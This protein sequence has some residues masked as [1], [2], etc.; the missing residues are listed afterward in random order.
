MAATPNDLAYFR[1]GEPLPAGSGASST[2]GFDYFRGGEPFPAGIVVDADEAD[3]TAHY[4]RHL[5][6][7]AS[8]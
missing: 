7:A 8:A 3:A 4:Y 1:G 5:L 2:T 6:R